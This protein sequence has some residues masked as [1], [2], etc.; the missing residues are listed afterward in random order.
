MFGAHCGCSSMP[1]LV[2]QPVDQRVHVVGAPRGLGQDEARLSEPSRPP[3]SSRRVS[4]APCRAGPCRARRCPAGRAAAR[5][6][7]PGPAPRRRCA[8]TMCT[9]PDRRPCGSGPPSRAMSTSSPVTLRTTSG[10]VTKIRPVV[11]QDHHVGQG[12]AV[13]GAAGRRAEHHR[14]LRHLARGPGHG[15]EHRPDRVQ[16]GHALGQPGAAG[17]PQPDHRRAAGE[18]LVVGGHDGRAA[19]AAHRAALD[20]RVAGE[21]HRRHPV[22]QPGAGQRAAVVVR[23]EQLQR[24]GS[25]SASSRASGSRAWPPGGRRA[26][27]GGRRG[28]RQLSTTVT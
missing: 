3:V 8:V 13:G 27:V 5:A 25:N 16:A 12:R 6:P 28:R 24:A 17:V 1:G 26:A 2:Q 21:R 7:G 9:T 11:G 14:D 4:A 10:P 18:R 20:P 22:D 23:G 19:G 15:R